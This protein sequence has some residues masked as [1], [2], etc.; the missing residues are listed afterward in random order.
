MRRRQADVHHC[1]RVP[2]AGYRKHFTVTHM[3]SRRLSNHPVP[4]RMLNST[5]GPEEKPTYE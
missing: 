4:N 3:R 1:S 5:T 2:E